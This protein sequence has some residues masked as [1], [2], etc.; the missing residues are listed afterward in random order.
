MKLTHHGHACVEL[1]QGET[2]ILVD[3]GNF[4]DFSTVRD[5]DAIVITH[6]HPDHLD[7]DKLDQLRSSNPHAQWFADPQTADKLT[8]ARVTVTETE[9]GKTYT[10]GDLTMEGVGSIHAQ[11]HPYIDRISNVGMVFSDVSGLRVFHPG[12]SLEGRPENIDYLL[13]PVTAPWQAVKET[14]EFVRELEPRSLI[15]IHDKTASDA[16]RT[17]YVTHIAGYGRDGGIDFIDMRAGDEKE[18]V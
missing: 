14:I 6:Q 3:P 1:T 8:E 7:M 13:V 18:L 11:I 15:P 9:A 4:S 2:T 17:M 5:A 16:G 10:V 12:D